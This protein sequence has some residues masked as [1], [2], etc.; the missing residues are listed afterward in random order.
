MF[1]CL[2]A[3]WYLAPLSTIFQLYR[4]ILLYWWRKPEDPAKTTDMSQVTDKL[5]HIM[6]YA[7]PWSRSELPTS[8]VIGTDCICSFKSIYHTITATTAP[9]DYMDCRDI[10][11]TFYTINTLTDLFLKSQRIKRY[12]VNLHRKILT[13][14]NVYYFYS[15]SY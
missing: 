4:G 9:V 5:D 8:V 1:V 11:R 7:S 10:W 12:F 6:L 15:F 3:W 14:F 13:L 2:F